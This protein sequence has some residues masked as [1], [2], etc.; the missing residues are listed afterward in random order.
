[1]THPDL[2]VV[3][4]GIVGVAA[5]LEIK[6]RHNLRILVVEK[7]AEPG[8]HA[9]GRNSGVLHAGF[10]YSADSLKARFC[11]EGNALW[12]AYCRDRRLPLLACGKLV[13]CRGPQDLPVLELLLERGKKNGVSLERLTANEARAIEP[14]VRTFESALYSPSTAT[15]DP[16]AVLS[17]LIQDARSLGIEFRFGL[18]FLSAGKNGYEFRE[19][20][21]RI[22]IAAPKF[23]NAAGLYAD[24]IAHVFG[25]GQ[26]YTILPFKGLYLYADGG[27]LACH[28]YP[29]P[30]PG[31]PFLGVHYT[32]TVDGRLKIGPTAIP[33]FWREQYD[34]RHPEFSEFFEIVRLQARLFLRSGFDFRR[35][36]LTEI[37]KYRRK[38]LAG[39]A[40]ELMEGE[41]RYSKWGRP[42]IRAQLLDLQENKL[43]M[44]FVTEGDEGSFHVLNAVSPA[45]T[46]A[47]P[48][49]REIV[50]RMEGCGS[51]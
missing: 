29:V 41:F 38:T 27:S 3:G 18:T 45:F 20:K 34:F 50:D 22:T 32:R 6:R 48:F 46:C 11:R 10:Y 47:L 26:R 30:D 33:A 14:R 13:V 1:M 4:A 28:I 8:L 43:E 9:S 2:I 17:S 37:R 36:A 12:T 23:L 49:A 31:Q 44:D 15:V 7:E 40:G 21:Q 39:F 24:R 16:L 51:L 25:H 5:A 35:L 19:G 42:G